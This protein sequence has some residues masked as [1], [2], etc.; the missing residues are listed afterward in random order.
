V[1]TY[2]TKFATTVCHILGTEP[3]FLV[4]KYTS[5]PPGVFELQ[6]DITMSVYWEYCP[7]QKWYW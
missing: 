3:L 1:Q 2:P 7:L 5:R 4:Y 6:C